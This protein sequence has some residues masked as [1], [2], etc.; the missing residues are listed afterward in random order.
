MRASVIFTLVVLWVGAASAAPPDAENGKRLA[1]L[2]KSRVEVARQMLDI[3]LKNYKDGNL[4]VVEVPYR[5]SCRLVEA[6]RQ[7][8]PLKADRLA[9]LQ[10]HLDRMRDVE[11]VARDRFR[12]RIISVDE[13][14]AAE[15]Y[16][17]EAEIW[18]AE[19]PQ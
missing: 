11:R 15:F 14:K 2:Y 8:S 3:V 10:A 7:A 5:W 9:S 12:S 18:L 4:P 16:R 17:I 13:V 1:K 19:A 6:E